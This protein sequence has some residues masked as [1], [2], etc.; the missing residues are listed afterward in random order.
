MQ[1]ASVSQIPNLLSADE[2]KNSSL[3]KRLQV[4]VNGLYEILDAHDCILVRLEHFDESQICYRSK[5]KLTSE[6]AIALTE[7]ADEI[8]KNTQMPL[9]RGQLLSFCDRDFCS[10]PQSWQKIVQQERIRSLALVPIVYQK[11]CLGKM[12][13][14]SCDREFQCTPQEE[15]QVKI[16]A[17]RCAIEIANERVSEQINEQKQQQKQQE[18]LWQIMQ[19]LNGDLDSEAILE[20]CLLLIGKSFRVNRA[21]I[22]DLQADSAKLVKEWRKNQKTLCLSTLK[23]SPWDEAKINVFR[24]QLKVGN[25]VCNQPKLSGAFLNLP[26]VIRGKFFGSLSLQTRL[27]GRKFS[28]PEMSLLEIVTQQLAIAIE[29]WQTQLANCAKD[30]IFSHLNHELRTP[31]SSILGYARMLKDE[32]YG[33][34]NEKQRQYTNVIVASGEHLL[35]LVNDYLDISKI[36]A[37]REELFLET[38]AVEDICLAS[39]SMVESRAKEQDLKLDLNIASDVDLCKADGLRIK[40]ILVNL[41]SN[42]IKF[43]EVG[44]VTLNV[45][46]HENMLEFCV[47]DTGI[48]IKEEDKEKLFQPF[49]Q[50]KND[51][52]CRHKG[53]G[54]GLA[55][56]RKLAQ[57]HGGDITLVSEQ[58]NGS[59][60]T[61]HLPV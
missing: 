35:S 52:S 36:E 14:Y 44:S 19:K 2:P 48:G 13:L 46:R 3:A 25:F 43:T 47:I 16:F 24:S 53:T 51:L 61:L 4:I 8:I 9:A 58:G 50:I 17:E 10:L 39:L 23:D 55:L 30:E 41:L 12:F 33:P 6:N 38:I 26:I 42:A 21:I 49:Q 22:F 29:R 31:L 40:Q 18:L 54:L 59:C 60:F 56:S 7:L 27:P 28:L 15:A 1:A 32:I 5:T 45:R 57:L 11:S 34:L 37:N 20:D